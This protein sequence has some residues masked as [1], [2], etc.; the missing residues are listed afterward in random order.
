LPSA[1]INRHGT[2]TGDPVSLAPTHEDEA[3]SDMKMF[4]L[5]SFVMT[6]CKRKLSFEHLNNWRMFVHLQ[7]VGIL[8][9]LPCSAEK[10]DFPDGVIA[11]VPKKVRCSIFN[12]I[13][14]I[15]D[16]DRHL[17]YLNVLNNG[18][19]LIRTQAWTISAKEWDVAFL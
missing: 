10:I 15:R 17:N 18:H 11:P 9:F 19:W 8:R 3:N 16:F 1:G 4:P 13:N 7:P 5:V 2:G 12:E 6:H 14:P